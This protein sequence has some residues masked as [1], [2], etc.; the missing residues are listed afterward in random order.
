[1]ASA[2]EGHGR[3]PHGRGDRSSRTWEIARPWLSWRRRLHAFRGGASPHA[4]LGS[5]RDRRPLAGRR[6]RVTRRALP[7]RSARRARARGY[8][9]AAPFRSG[10]VAGFTGRGR[11]GTSTGVGPVLGLREQH[12]AVD[13]VERITSP[14]DP[15]VT[16]SDWIADDTFD[17]MRRVKDIHVPTLIT[18]GADDRLTPVKYHQYLA[19]QIPGSQLTIVEKAGHWMFWEQPD[20]FTKHLRAFLD[21]LPSAATAR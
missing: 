17:V 2:H 5:L 4:P 18:C 19:A 3:P 8:G 6:H 9:G 1:M 12:A 16:Y 10:A 14:T 13:A 21:H 7:R 15:R 11:E 20:A